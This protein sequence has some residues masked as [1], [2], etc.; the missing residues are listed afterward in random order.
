VKILFTIFVACMFSKQCFDSFSRHSAY[1]TSTTIQK[2]DTK[3]LKVF[4]SFLLCPKEG[5]DMRKLLEKGYESMSDFYMG[6]LANGMRGWGGLK[7]ESFEQILNDIG[8]LSNERS[9]CNNL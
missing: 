6:R 3:D 2:K 7:N 8:I 9:A 5:I 1:P 4:P